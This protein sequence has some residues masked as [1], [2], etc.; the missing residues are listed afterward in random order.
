MISACVKMY[1]IGVC[2]VF[3]PLRTDLFTAIYSASAKAHT[4]V[5]VYL[6]IHRINHIS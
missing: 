1:D 2:H 3:W 5:R 4:G 6:V